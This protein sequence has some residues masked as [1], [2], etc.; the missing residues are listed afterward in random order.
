SEA[1]NELLSYALDERQTARGRAF[2]LGE[3]LVS[4]GD[5]QAADKRLAAIGAVTAADVQRVAQAWFAPQARVDF[6][7]AEGADDIAAYANPVPMPQF[8]TV[9]PASGEPDAVRPEGERQPPPPP[10]PVPEVAQVAFVEATL[11]NGIPLVAAQTG[12]V[13]IAT[14]TVV[15]PGGSASDPAGKEG[16]ASFAAAL[17]GKGTPDRDARQIA[18]ELES[19][20]AS[21]D[22]SAGS[23]GEYASLTAPV[24][25]LA[26]AGA[27]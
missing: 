20:G 25:N 27:V 5:P 16:L 14:I 18:A 15:L 12:E 22:V 10:G 19:L 23:D 4:T 2:E 6:T 11:T 9:P 3:A 7:Y 17:A 13:P 21:L 26:A 1:K 8:L 24:A